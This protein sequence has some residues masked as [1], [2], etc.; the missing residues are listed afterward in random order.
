MLYLCHN[1]SIN[2]LLCA[3]TVV[4]KFLTTENWSVKMLN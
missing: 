4:K 1:V 2:R 3:Q